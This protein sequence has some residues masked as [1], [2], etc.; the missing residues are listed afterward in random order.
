MVLFRIYGYA[1]R[2]RN[3]LRNFGSMINWVIRDESLHLKFGM[4]LILNILEEN[5]ELLTEDFANE[6]RKYNH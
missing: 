5:S 1:F 6:I 4:N 3:K 2:Q